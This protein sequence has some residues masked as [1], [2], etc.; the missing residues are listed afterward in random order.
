MLIKHLPPV[1]VLHIKRFVIGDHLVY[2]NDKYL[3]FTLVLNMAPYCTG[4]YSEVCS[5]V[6]LSMCVCVA[7]CACMYV[8]MCVCVCVCMY[9][10]AVCTYMCVC[11]YIHKCVYV[12][13]CEYV[14][15]TVYVHS[16]MCICS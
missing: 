13:A 4:A 15:V 11:V 8:R 9:M 10:C 1:L 7:T 3:S 2:K 5:F 16:Y 6:C 12:C 14:C